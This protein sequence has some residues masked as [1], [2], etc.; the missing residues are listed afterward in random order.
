M[1]HSID[2]RNRSMRMGNLIS[3]SAGLADEQG[4]NG[5]TGHPQKPRSGLPTSLH[6]QKQ[7]VSSLHVTGF[8]FF[9]SFGRK[10]RITPLRTSC[11]EGLR[12]N[13]LIAR[14]LASRPMW[15]LLL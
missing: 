15:A 2:A 13:C 3:D 4:K 12:L 6:I 9:F 10:H 14:A 11:G 5:P 1:K 7:Q 8:F